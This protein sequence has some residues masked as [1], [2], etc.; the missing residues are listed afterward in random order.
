VPATFNTLNTWAV[1]IADTIAVSLLCEHLGHGTP[2]IVVACLKNDLAKLPA[3]PKA[4][5]LLKRSGVRMLYAPRK[6]AAPQIVPWDD[7]LRQFTVARP[8]PMRVTTDGRDA[9]DVG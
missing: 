5:Q 8:S 7:I 6:S 9:V 3:F 1:G 4:M 2:S